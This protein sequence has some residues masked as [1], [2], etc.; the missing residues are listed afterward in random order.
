MRN[1]Y[2]RFFNIQFS[3]TRFMLSYMAILYV[4]SVLIRVRSESFFFLSNFNKI[5]YYI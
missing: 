5:K 1:A 2:I 4:F 3:H